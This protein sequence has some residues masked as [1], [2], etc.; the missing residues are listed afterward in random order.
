MPSLLLLPQLAL[1]Y[2][3]SLCL[4]ACCCCAIVHSAA[5]IQW[6]TV[7]ST[8]PSSAPSPAAVTC[9]STATSVSQ[10]QALENRA[11]ER[12]LELERGAAPELWSCRFLPGAGA[13]P[14]RSSKALLEHEK[15]TRN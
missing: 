8:T 4:A 15:L 12:S 6:A 2:C 10:Y 3:Q 1:T 9:F 5:V 7:H 11:L 13:E 14:E